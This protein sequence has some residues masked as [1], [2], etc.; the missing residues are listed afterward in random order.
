VV[1]G[2][3]SLGVLRRVLLAG[4]TR[5]RDRCIAGCSSGSAGVDCD[6][7]NTGIDIATKVISIASHAYTKKIIVFLRKFVSLFAKS[8]ENL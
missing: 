5:L 3:L 1:G 8:Y 6:I 7:N 4:W 2:P